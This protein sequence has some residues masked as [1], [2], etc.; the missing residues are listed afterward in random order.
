MYS[1]CLEK[2]NLI[3]TQ[4]EAYAHPGRI[5]LTIKKQL[6]AETTRKSSQVIT[7]QKATNM[8]HP[9]RM[10]FITHDSVIYI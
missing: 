3:L 4:D 6:S 10:E 2:L 5:K 7:G 8:R 1:F 9:V